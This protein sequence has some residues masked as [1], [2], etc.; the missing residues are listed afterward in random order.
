MPRLITCCERDSTGVRP[1]VPITQSGCARAVSESRLI[2]S[3]SNHRPNS[4]P[5]SS[6]LSTSGCS[7]VGQTSIETVQSPR[8]ARSS[9]RE[10]NHPSSRTNRST[11]S[12]RRRLGQGDQLLDV[13][14]EVDRLPDVDRHRSIDRRMLI[15]GAQ[16]AVEAAGHGV[17][18][19]P[20]RGVDP[21][22]RVTGPLIQDDLVG[23]QQLAP[24]DHLLAGR[25]PFGVVR[26]VAAPPGV[27]RP[28][29]LRPRTRSRVR[30]GAARS[31][32]RPRSGPCALP[33]G[34]CRR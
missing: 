24:A 7:P 19:D 3:G 16:I 23:Q 30:R 18:A 10:A 32:R 4:M 6:T 11:P 15:A 33:A 29:P 14:V 27:Q 9:R 12:V 17:Q 25:Q 13:V 8:P 28:R 34:G 5:R 21:R 26:V 20:V 22:S 1:P 31:R 2:I